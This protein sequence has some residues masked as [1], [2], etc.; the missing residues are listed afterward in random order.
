VRRLKFALMVTAVL[1]LTASVGIASGASSADWTMFLHDGSHSSLSGD[2]TVTPANVAALKQAWKW[3]PP[4]ISGRPA[5]TLYSTPDV[6]NG[7]VYEGA[8]TGVFYAVSLA[9]GKVVWTDDLK[10]YQPHKTCEGFGIVASPA[11]ANDP[12]T[13]KLTIYEN[14]NNGYL[15]AL[16]AATGTVVWKSVT[17]LPSSTKNDYMA[18]SSP[19]VA[20]G[21]V[22]VGLA[23]DCDNPLVPGAEMKFSQ[24][25]GALQKTYKA[26]AGAPAGTAGATIWS[27][28]AATSTD[29][30]V[31]TGNAVSSSS[32]QGD[33]D[34]IVD[35][36]A[37]TM[38]KKAI[39]TLPNAQ[40]VSDG[41]FGA[42]PTLFTATIGGVATPMVGACNKNGQYYALNATTMNLVWQYKVDTKRGPCMAAAI[43]DGSHLFIAGNPTKIGG[44]S[45][46]GS[47][48]E[49]NPATGAAVW[50]TGLTNGITGSPSESGG[51]V[52]AV[53]SWDTNNAVYLINAST[54]AII[55][56]ITQSS[57][58]FAQ[59]VFADGYLLT[60]TLNGGLVAY[61]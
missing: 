1:V 11:A 33:S 55:R 38:A 41:D 18:W 4:V 3:T 25:T 26:M 56:T 34:S 17:K 15:Y 22:Y 9:T 35:L 59:P 21:S 40:Q 24:A 52:I 20:N 46:R 49:L 2:A 5:H 61:H 58:E 44:T 12:T 42:S 54:G 8:D 6:V 37:T 13:G 7:V 60:P 36:N 48:R 14:G 30:Y 10:A 57:K 16:D 47:I 19:T 51:G 29:V 23:S 45:Y 28:A 43:W 53:A 32:P 50:Q 27:T 31:T 39:W